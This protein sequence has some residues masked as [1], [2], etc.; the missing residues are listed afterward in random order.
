MQKVLSLLQSAK[1]RLSE[2]VDLEIS[3]IQ[4]ALR[5]IENSNID[6]DAILYLSSNL[7]CCLQ[8]LYGIQV[9]YSRN[10]T[11]MIA[12]SIEAYNEIMDECIELVN[13]HI[14]PLIK[15]IPSDLMFELVKES[16]DHINRLEVGYAGFD[17]ATLNEMFVEKVQKIIEEMTQKSQIMAEFVADDYSANQKAE[18]CGRD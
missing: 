10:Q 14:V 12:E 7:E 2:N 6:T 1:T 15:D 18:K 16:V 4:E 17:K 13:A 3:Q 9:G 11:D 8:N 5:L